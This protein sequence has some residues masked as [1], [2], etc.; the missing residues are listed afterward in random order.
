[1]LLAAGLKG[2][3]RL[4]SHVVAHLD[5]C[6]IETGNETAMGHDGWPFAANLG[7]HDSWQLKHNGPFELWIRVGEGY[8]V[9]HSVKPKVSMGRV[10]AVLQ[11]R[12]EVG[13][14]R[15]K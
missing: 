13:S 15:F 8:W 2:E 10:N 11:G 9:W 4:G 14:G 7:R 6:R 3:L 1:M 12:P 5:G